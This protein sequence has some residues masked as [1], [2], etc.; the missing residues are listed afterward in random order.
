MVEKNSVRVRADVAEQPP[1]QLLGE[2]DS[3]RAALL[4]RTGES[5]RVV[6]GPASAER[7]HV[8]E[9]CLIAGV[10]SR[11]RDA[12]ARSAEGHVGHGFDLDA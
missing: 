9:Q 1:G 4:K 2:H 6:V 12:A 11:E 8:A 10:D 7:A 5:Y 3:A